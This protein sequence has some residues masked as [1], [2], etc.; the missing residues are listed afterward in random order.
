MRNLSARMTVVSLVYLVLTALLLTGT[1]HTLLDRLA[2]AQMNELGNALS[3]QLSE[4][5]KQPVIDGDVIS[6]QVILENLLA[7]T[8]V[9]ARATVYST[10][11]RIIS[12]S[13]RPVAGDV[14]P[15]INPISVDDNMLAQVRL[16]LDV[17]KLMAEYRSPMWIALVI[18]LASSGVLVWYVIRLARDYSR[19]I[20]RINACF[21]GTETHRDSELAAL[22]SSVSPFMDHG[23]DRTSAGEAASTGF[24]MLAVS[25]PN[26]PK[27]QAQLNAEH[28]TAMLGKID[29]LLD[30][31]LA[32]FHGRR[33]QSR[34]TATILEFD[35]AGGED[36]LVRAVNCANAFLRLS[37]DLVTGDNM[38]FE[39]RITAAFRRLIHN[40]SPWFNDLAREACVDRLV[41]ILPLAG[42][43]ELVVDKSEVDAEQLS[44]C[45]VEDL[46]A[47]S[48]WQF[49]GYTGDRE[50][51]FSRQ[52]E[53]L[54]AVHN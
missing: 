23:G 32:L 25:I 11:N 7:E 33:L 19:R 31:H 34:A 42:P 36:A 39:L 20:E 8:P 49:R 3:A 30:N 12:Q 9:I 4:T 17:D 54:A 35:D 18:W 51:A 21:A 48:V 16:E 47:A 26:L 45:E 22:E 2:R 50:E 15:Y 38:P 46:S 40:G 1:L 53:I 6:T 52:T 44:D 13:Q 5:L 37:R 14:A 29:A 43:W 41:D 27:W 28:F 10:S 24:A